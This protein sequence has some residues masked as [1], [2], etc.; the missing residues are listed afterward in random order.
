[1]A[2]VD[3]FLGETQ[4]LLVFRPPVSCEEYFN[5]KE[6]DGPLRGRGIVT[7]VYSRGALGKP[8]SRL[9]NIQR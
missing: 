3:L 1:M 8:K 5:S 7:I 2:N 9:R 6:L 4:L